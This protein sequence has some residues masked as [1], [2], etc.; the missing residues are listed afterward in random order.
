MTVIELAI[1]DYVYSRA[2]TD[3]EFSKQ[4]EDAIKQRIVDG[5]WKVFDISHLWK[6]VNNIINEL[7]KKFTEEYTQQEFVNAL[8]KNTPDD[9]RHRKIRI[10]DMPPELVDMCIR[11]A[12]K[13]PVTEAAM[14]LF[15]NYWK[16]KVKEAE[17]TEAR[18]IILHDI[19]P[20]ELKDAKFLA[21]PKTNW[22]LNKPISLKEQFKDD[23]P[24]LGLNHTDISVLKGKVITE[25]EGL[26]KDGDE[27][28]IKT[29]D[30]CVYKMYHE[31][32]CCESV[33]IE[34]VCGDVED[35]I[36]SPVLVAEKCTNAEDLGE[37]PDS[38]YSH[39]WTFYKLAT[40]KGY[41]D[42]RWYG[43]SNGYYSESVDFK[44][45][46]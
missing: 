8:M 45:L 43:T 31:Q 38:D 4:L 9:N 32:D 33:W 22:K 6:D 23:R 12:E 15:S 13:Q 5:D 27:I 1:L 26:K 41:V 39:T 37:L 24:T 19:D 25:I 20:K 36:G 44:Q 35:L 7:D 11:Y 29:S 28:Y 46:K 3:K 18:G 2:E 16:A 14:G 40:A 17:A 34:D 42:I 30:G 10:D 21:P